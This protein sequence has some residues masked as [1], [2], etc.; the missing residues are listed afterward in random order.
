MSH[1]FAAKQ[2]DNRSEVGG[3]GGRGESSTTTANRQER[4]GRH[5]NSTLNF[6][7]ATAGDDNSKYTKLTPPQSRH[8]RCRGPNRAPARATTWSAM[9]PGDAACTPQLRLHIKAAEKICP[10]Y[11]STSVFSSS[12]KT[13]QQKRTIK[14]AGWLP[15]HHIIYMS[16]VSL[17]ACSVFSAWQYPS[18]K[19]LADSIKRCRDLKTKYF[20]F[21]DSVAATNGRSCLLFIVFLLFLWAPRVCVRVCAGARVPFFRSLL[22]FRAGTKPTNEKTLRLYI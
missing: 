4:T 14:D 18:G 12:S 19:A 10:Q 11:I 5:K 20:L 22:W 1:R 21:S 2:E 15:R 8:P 6:R 13:L 17:F 16:P 3:G 9:T 7:H